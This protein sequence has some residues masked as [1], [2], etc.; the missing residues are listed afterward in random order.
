VQYQGH[1]QLAER[2]PPPP[3]A[4][5]LIEVEPPS[6]DDV[7]DAAFAG[8]PD[9]LREE[10]RLLGALLWRPELHRR[11]EL[12][13]EDFS[14]PLHERIY[15][16][17]R[18]LWRMGR[19]ASASVVAD[20]LWLVTPLCAAGDRLTPIEVLVFDTLAWTFPEYILELVRER[21]DDIVLH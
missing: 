11:V 19:H 21:P 12:R 7:A 3:A 1:H 5:D 8:L 4:F 15:G 2:T 6:E 20:A 16:M 10:Q 17:A 9:E 18:G 14:D 13:P